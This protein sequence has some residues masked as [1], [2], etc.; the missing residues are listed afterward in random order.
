[1]HRSMR[2]TFLTKS[3]L[4]IACPPVREFV[5][6][7]SYYADETGSQVLERNGYPAARKVHEEIQVDAPLGTRLQAGLSPGVLRLDLPRGV[8]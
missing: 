5:L 6:F 2:L 3:Y 4:E 1:M 8:A 7:V